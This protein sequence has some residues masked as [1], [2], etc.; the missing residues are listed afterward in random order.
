M[1]THCLQ[2]YT[3][4]PLKSFDSD[5]LEG[6]AEPGMIRAM[7]EIKGECLNL[8]IRVHFPVC[9]LLTGSQQAGLP[10]LRTWVLTLTVKE[11]TCVSK[12]FAS[13]LCARGLDSHT[14]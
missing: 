12:V 9:L 8:F 14:P 1:H 13:K 10:G 4:W 5:W 7:R 3:K 6:E 2:F 11:Q